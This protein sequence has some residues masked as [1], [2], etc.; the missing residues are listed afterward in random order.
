MKLPILLIATLL[1]FG[2]MAQPA[3]KA[4][5]AAAKKEAKMAAHQKVGNQ[6]MANQ[7]VPPILEKLRGMSPDERQKALKTLP[8]ARRERL[9]ARLEAY[10]RMNERQRKNVERFQQLPAAQQ[11]QVRKVYQRFNQLPNDRKDDLRQEVRKIS[12][13]SEDARKNYLNSEEF[14][15]KYNDQEQQMIHQLA[16]SFANEK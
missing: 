12:P 8:P 10:D 14:R 16:D 4:A 7:K 13:M 11:Q 15:A 3:N 6:K 1:C 2:V 9:E 5:N